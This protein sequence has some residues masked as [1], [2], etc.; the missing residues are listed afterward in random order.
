MFRSQDKVQRWPVHRRP[1]AE[2]RRAIFKWI[3]WYNTSR[4]DDTPSTASHRSSGN[5]GAVKRHNHPSGRR[6]DAHCEHRPSFRTDAASVAVLAAQRVDTQAL[7]AD[8]EARGWIDE[9]DRHRKLLDRL[10][11]LIAQASG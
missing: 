11:A 10:D 7:A 2:A 9:A 1:R 5:S 4:L 3:N 6:G 8:A